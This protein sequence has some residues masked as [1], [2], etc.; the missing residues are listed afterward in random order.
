AHEDH[1]ARPL[2]QHEGEILGAEQRRRLFVD[3]EADGAGGVGGV[4]GGGDIVHRD[5]IDAPVVD[6]SAGAESGDDAGRHFA[7]AALQ[8]VTDG[9]RQAAH[10]ADEI[11]RFG[12]DIVGGAGVEAGDGY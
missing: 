6:L 12:D 8:R 7:Y 9:D 5:R 2:F 4:D 3:R 10:G 11:G 1:R